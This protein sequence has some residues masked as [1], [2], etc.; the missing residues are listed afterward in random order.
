MLFQASWDDFSTGSIGDP[1][2]NDF[3]GTDGRS[4]SEFTGISAGEAGSQRDMASGSQQR[5]V[6][7]HEGS[8]TADDI[9]GARFERALGNDPMVFGDSLQGAIQPEAREGSREANE[10][11]LQGEI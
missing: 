2:T 9:D 3:G 4:Q 10:R 11:E 8:S 7:H 1:L 5:D 6:V